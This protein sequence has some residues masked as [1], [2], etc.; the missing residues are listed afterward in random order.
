MQLQVL[1]T[2]AAAANAA[3][4]FIAAQAQQA[5]AARGRFLLAVSGGRTPWLMLD[6]LAALDVR[7]PAV[8][9]FQVDERVAP[10]GS[11]ER[12]FAHIASHLLRRVPLPAAQVHPMP[13]DHPDLEAAA[14]DYAAQLRASAGDPPL[15]DLVHLGLGDDG[16]TASLMP[17]DPALDVTDRLVAV[18]GEYQGRRRL[19]L[20]FPVLNAARCR[21][22]LITGPDKVAVL[23]RLRAA[24]P[25]IPAGRVAQ[26]NGWVWA[27]RAATGT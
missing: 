13:V 14:R 11:G 2:P 12:N 24:D 25:A 15:L 3:A 7:W 27:D 6:A 1:D 16:H 4:D 18:S 21:L 10:V 5:V 23:P 20:T 17:G 26:A 9:L 22:W 8:H 19:T